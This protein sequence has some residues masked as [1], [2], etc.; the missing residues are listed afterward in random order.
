MK[1]DPLHHYDDKI[2]PHSMGLHVKY[3]KF[4]LKMDLYCMKLVTKKVSQ[5]LK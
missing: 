3:K 4:I 2:T 5:Q 1:N